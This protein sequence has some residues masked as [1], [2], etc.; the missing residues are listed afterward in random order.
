[1]ERVAWSSILKEHGAVVK[2]ALALILYSLANKQRTFRYSQLAIS[3]TAHVSPS[4]VQKA[5]YRLKAHGLLSVRTYR[6]PISGTDR[7]EV[8]SWYH[9]RKYPSMSHLIL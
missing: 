9:I 8:F 7:L 2:V 5:V 6:K 3:K 4:A 1:M